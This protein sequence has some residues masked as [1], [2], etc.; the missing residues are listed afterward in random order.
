MFKRFPLLKPLGNLFLPWSKLR[1][2]AQFRKQS[3]SQLKDRIQRRGATEHPDFFEYFLP[4]GG[5]NQF[6]DPREMANVGVAARQLVFAG[7]QPVSELLYA[8]LFYLAH[9]PTVYKVLVSEIRNRF[10]RYDDITSDALAPLPY[11]TAV[12][13]EGLRLFPGNNSGL[14]RI[15]PGAVVDGVYVPKGVSRESPLSFR[16]FLAADKVS[17]YPD[18]CS[19]FFLCQ[20]QI[21]TLLP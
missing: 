8:V 16:S 11:L 6:T 15:S 18:S 7:Y 9:D 3:E 5:D 2:Y 12:L 14:P 17:S 13:E 21:A 1:T 20:F 19:D 4:S 10:Q